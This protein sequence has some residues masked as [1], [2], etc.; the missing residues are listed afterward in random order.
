MS[1]I[2]DAFAPIE[3]DDRWFTLGPL[4]EEEIANFETELGLPVPQAVKELLA[5][6]GGSEWSG[7]R[8]VQFFEVTAMKDVNPEL[9]SNWI[10]G[11]FAFASDGGPSWYIVDTGDQLKRGEGTVWALPAGGPFPSEARYVA[12]NIPDFVRWMIQGG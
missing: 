8:H 5:Y 4:S 6:T 10:P 9:Q 1:E 3:S 2:G 12:A 11:A 7:R